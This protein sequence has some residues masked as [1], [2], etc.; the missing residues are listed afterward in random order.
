M[1]EIDWT[2]HRVW[3]AEMIVAE[4]DR[5]T[6]LEYGKWGRA[7]EI[8]THRR[9]R[10]C[11]ATY[12]YEI[13]DDPIMPDHVWDMIAQQINPKLGTCHPL[14]DEFFA[15][16]FSPMTGMWIHNH[17]ELEGIKRLY[18]KYSRRK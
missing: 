6:E 18:E 16:E 7:I 11:V 12:A 13:A 1:A 2:K 15:A 4:R 10:L 17:P 5:L 9:I 8:E 14:V 3:S